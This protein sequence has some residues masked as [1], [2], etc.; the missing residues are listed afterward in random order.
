MSAGSK[1]SPE[2]R[3]NTH[4]P[5]GGGKGNRLVLLGHKTSS[6]SRTSNVRH[7]ASILL[8]EVTPHS[9]RMQSVDEIYSLLRMAGT[10]KQAVAAMDRGAP[11]IVLSALV[12]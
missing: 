10:R 12:G 9:V 3:G 11:S 6:E 5:H 1:R 2:P 7:E 8:S 4:A